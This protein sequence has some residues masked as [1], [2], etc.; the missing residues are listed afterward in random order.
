MTGEQALLVVADMVDLLSAAS[1]DESLAA[2]AGGGE[3]TDAQAMRVVSSLLR[4]H[5]EEVLRLVADVQGVSLE[6]YRKAGVGTIVADATAVLTDDSLSD[7]LPS[8]P[9]PSP[10][11]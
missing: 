2:I 10:S 1:G 3:V 8:A 6:D 9:A 7:F 4:G 5:P 11:A